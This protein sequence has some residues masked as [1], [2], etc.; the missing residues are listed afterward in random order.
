MSNNKSTSRSTRRQLSARSRHTRVSARGET[1][2]QTNSPVRLRPE[3][4]KQIDHS[5]I[6]LCF[7]LLA[8]RIVKEAEENG[9]LTCPDPDVH[10]GEAGEKL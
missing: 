4:R 7:W 8:Q 3:R 2:R 9:D 6:A 5:T 10:E 1:H